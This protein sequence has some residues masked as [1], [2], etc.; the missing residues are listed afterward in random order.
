M[1]T[2]P[3]RVRF[4][5][6]P[7]ENTKKY[8]VT[9]TTPDDIEVTEAPDGDPWVVVAGRLRAAARREIMAWGRV[10]QGIDEHTTNPSRPFTV[11]SGR[12]AS[13]SDD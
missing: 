9:G 3:P 13:V 12:I 1:R 6:K 8:V 2:S 4:P 5:R 11:P 7:V 10:I